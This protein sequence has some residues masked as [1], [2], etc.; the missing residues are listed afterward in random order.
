M[1]PRFATATSYT[2]GALRYDD[3]SV[4][5]FENRIEN[6]FGNEFRFLVVPTTTLVAEYRFELVSY[7]SINRDSTSHFALGGF[8]HTFSPELNVSFRGGAQFREYDQGGN[9]TSPYFEGTL[10]YNVGKRTI[11]SWINRYSIEE[12]DVLLSQSRETFRTG[13]SARHQFS[14]KISA[15]GSAYYEHDEY[16]SFKGPGF[17][18]PSFTEEDLDLALSLRYA[19]TRYIGIEAGYNFTNVWSDVSAREYTRNRYWAGVNVTF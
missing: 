15:A 16:Q 17:M 10:N 2:I 5:L 4:G 12:P 13:V 1:A 8:D 18:F 9:R 6:T 3:K 19:I 11:V 14:P 7:E